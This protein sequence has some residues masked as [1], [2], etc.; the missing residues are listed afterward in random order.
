MKEN[1]PDTNLSAREFG[2]AQHVVLHRREAI[3]N[4]NNN[5]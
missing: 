2:V 3:C 1:Y 5:L 4:Q